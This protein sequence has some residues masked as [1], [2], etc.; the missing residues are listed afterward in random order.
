MQKTILDNG[1]ESL[2]LNRS[3]TKLDTLEHRGIENVDTG[4][5]A[6]AD[7]FDG[8]LDKAVNLRGVA[9]LMDYDTVL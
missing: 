2:L 7:E 6:V 8:L 1:G 3:R 4:V 9:R 5:D